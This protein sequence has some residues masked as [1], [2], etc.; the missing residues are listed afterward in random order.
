MKVILSMATIS[1][2]KQRLL[3][4]LE[5]LLKQSYFFDKLIINI[6]E[7]ISEEDFKFYQC[8]PVLDERIEIK[9][10]PG[11]WRS[12][13]KLIWTLKEYPDDVIIT[14]DDDV[15]YPVDSILH[16]VNGYHKHPG[17]II[18][19]DINPIIVKEKKF[20]GYTNNIDIKCGQAE[21][22]KYLSNC[23]LFPPHVFD[24]TDLYDYDK[25]M[26]CTNGTHDELWFWVNSTL[27]GVQS[28]AL[29]YIYTFEFDLKTPYTDDEYRLALENLKEDITEQYGENIRKLYGERLTEII[30]NKPIVFKITKDNYFKF[31]FFLSYVFKYYSYNMYID[32]NDLTLGYEIDLRKHIKKYQDLV[33][34]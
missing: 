29:D 26:L 19:H 15:Y 21:F 16:L 34:N 23:C 24:N 14:V 22:G 6:D 4:N 3:E 32:M 25:M 1:S 13:N 12:C 11:K 7:E 20:Y 28:I 9:S 5:S 27:N 2:R 30:V 33:E 31:M 18:T 17:Y 10:R 8:I